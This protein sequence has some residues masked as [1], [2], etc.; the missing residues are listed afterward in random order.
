MFSLKI[1]AWTSVGAKRIAE[2]L[3]PQQG[4]DCGIAIKTDPTT[5]NEVL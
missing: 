3:D 1:G 2:R 4:I 5:G